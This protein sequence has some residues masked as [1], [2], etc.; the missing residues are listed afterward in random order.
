MLGAFGFDPMPFLAGA[1][2]LGM[3]LGLGAQPLIND[4]VSGF[5]ILFEN[6][7][8]VG[9]TIRTVGDGQPA[10]G[11]VEGID[12]RTTRL[13]DAD[14]NLHV[15]RN[16]DLRHSINYSKEY[17]FAV[18]EVTVAYG[19]PLDRAI[20]IMTM[21]GSHMVDDPRVLV[22]LEVRG[23]TKLG[24]QGS[25]L[26]AVMRVKPGEHFPISAAM[27]LAVITAFEDNGIPLA[28][29]R[30]QVADQIDEELEGDKV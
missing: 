14:G 11:T 13:R 25:H 5:F 4:I 30:Y 20:E 18:L 21:A 12:F 10:Y 29:Q 24:D 23:I 7:Y 27:R 22:P 17:T 1:G 6:T 8:L 19:A 9:D 3:V 15:L 16:G 26:R 28:A 2:I